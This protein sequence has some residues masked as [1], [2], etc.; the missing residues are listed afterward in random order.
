MRAKKLRPA[1]IRVF[2][3]KRILFF[4]RLFVMSLVS[5]AQ[6]SPITTL[7][8]YVF[9]SSDANKYYSNSDGN[10]IYIYNWN[11][12]LYK[13][14]SVVPPSGYSVSGISCFSKKF[15]NNDDNIEMCVTLTATS[16]SGDNSYQKMW[17]I[18]EDGTKLN[19]FGNGYLFSASFA[20][21]N[22]ET[23]LSILKTTINPT[24]Y[25]TTI[26]RCSGSGVINIALPDEN[27]IGLAY[28]NPAINVITLPYQLKDKL[29]SHIHI[30]N[31]S[32]KLITTIPIGTHFNEIKV[33]VSSYSSGIYFYECEGITN[34]FI[35]Q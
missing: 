4:I 28:P 23:H 31:E 20:S 1:Q 16:H 15:I 30:Y 10:V 13:T 17:L 2:K 19:D 22:G 34:S 8:W 14:V 21:Y 6:I 25:S 27:V 18:N 24:A 29:T 9:Y 26:Y 5:T 35:V 12:S 11:G 32:G 33:D 7:P 3:M